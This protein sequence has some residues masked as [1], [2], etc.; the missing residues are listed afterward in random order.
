MTS[1][2]MDSLFTNIPLEKT[3]NI[4]VEK[5]FENNTKVNNLAKECFQSLLKLVTLHS[6]FNFDGKYYKQKD[7]IAM[8]SP[9]GP[10]LANVF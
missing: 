4:F 7:G 1:F 3:I 8:R 10:T 9:L 2:H 6:F 5:L